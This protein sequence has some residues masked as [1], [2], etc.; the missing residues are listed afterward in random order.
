MRKLLFT[1]I[2]LVS[3]A[4]GSMAQGLVHRM[5]GEPSQIHE[6]SMPEGAWYFELICEHEDAMIHVDQVADGD[7]FANSLSAA[8]EGDARLFFIQT[9]NETPTEAGQK[10]QRIFGIGFTKGEGNYA[11]RL[12][13]Y[14]GK[15][16]LSSE[17][18]EEQYKEGGPW[19]Y[20]VPVGDD[21]PYVTIQNRKT[22]KMLTL[23]PLT[24]GKYELILSNP[25]SAN[26]ADQHWKFRLRPREFFN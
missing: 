11:N 23:G 25:K 6:V 2:L 17:L 26:N 4:M 14:K 3:I 16:V 10:T 21:S 12:Y 19:W 9:S 24:D 22:K 1:G 20:I 7:R 15:P 18:S 13:D 5:A 8:K